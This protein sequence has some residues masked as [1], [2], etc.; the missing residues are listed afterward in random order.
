LYVKELITGDNGR[1]TPSFSEI[2]NAK[3]ECNELDVIE[4]AEQ[5]G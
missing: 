3:T 4:V 2:L 5:L 1:T